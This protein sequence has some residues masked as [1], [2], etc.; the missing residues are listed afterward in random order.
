[1]HVVLGLMTLALA[2]LYLYSCSRAGRWRLY[3]PWLAGQVATAFRDVGGLLRGKIPSAEGGGLFAVIE[4]L[5]LLA[6]FVAAAT[7]A[8]WFALHGANEALAW[9]EW[10]IVSAR[11]LV[12]IAVLHVVTVS[13]HLLEL[14]RD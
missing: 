5:A 4:G 3:F 2:A 12:G 8:V 13:L 9:R 6:L 11:V 1:M 7:G 10:H 14:I